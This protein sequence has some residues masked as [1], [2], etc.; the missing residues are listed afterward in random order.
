MVDEEY[1]WEKEYKAPEQ[2]VQQPLMPAQLPQQQV[3]K[4]KRHIWGH[5]TTGEGH[6]IQVFYKCA[7]CDAAYACEGGRYCL[8]S[9]RQ[10]NLFGLLSEGMRD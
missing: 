7:T 6:A 8:V 2:P 3:R 4:T 9:G 5:V 10:A 1:P